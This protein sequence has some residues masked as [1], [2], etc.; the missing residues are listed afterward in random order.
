MRTDF[1]AFLNDSDYRAWF[2]RWWEAD[3][4]IDGCDRR[5]LD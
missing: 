4:S 1:E 3:F 2:A 5:N